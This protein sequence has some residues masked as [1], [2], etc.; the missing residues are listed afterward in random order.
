MSAISIL[1]ILTCFHLAFSF[2]THS[3][4]SKPYNTFQTVRIPKTGTTNFLSALVRARRTINPNAAICDEHIH[5][6]EFDDLHMLEPIFH[7]TMLRDPVERCMSSWTMRFD[8]NRTDKV[9]HIQSCI[10][11]QISVLAP[12]SSIAQQIPKYNKK[13]SLLN[14]THQNSTHIVEQILFAYDFIGITERFEESMVLLA[15]QLGVA[16]NDVLY[17]S[18][19]SSGEEYQGSD[20]YTNGKKIPVLQEESKEVQEAAALLRSESAVEM[21]LL[22]LVNKKLDQAIAKNKQKFSRD[23]MA[24]QSYLEYVDQFCRDSN[25]SCW[26]D[27]IGCAQDCIDQTMAQVY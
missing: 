2:V 21:E 24:L 27:D 22:R 12:T 17:L 4:S 11:Y 6:A 19:K 14:S 20:P 25:E 5:R 18:Q 3:R 1:Y 10:N 26:Q 16:I 8:S 23:L 13:M 9:Q 15:Y 7:A